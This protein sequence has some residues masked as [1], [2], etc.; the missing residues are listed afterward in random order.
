MQKSTYEFISKQANDAI[1][2]RRTCPRTGEEFPIFDSEV[3]LLEKLSPVIAGPVHEGGKKYQLS[4]PTLSPKARQIK[5]LVRRNERRF[6][7]SPSG[8]STISPETGLKTLSQS[9][10]FDHDHMSHGVEYSGDFYADMKKIFKAMPYPNRLNNN[11]ENA[12]YCQQETDD[13]NCYLNA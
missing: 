6:Y 9:D 8:V 4:L 12:E 10:F 5:R 3:K 13:K 2:E 1:L 7:K 11:M